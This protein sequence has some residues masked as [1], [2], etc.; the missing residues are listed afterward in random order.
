MSGRLLTVAVAA[1]I[2]AAGFVAPAANASVRPFDGCGAA[3]NDVGSPGNLYAFA[4]HEYVGQVEQQYQV[5]GGGVVNARGHFQWSGTFQARY[6]GFMVTVEIDSHHYGPTGGPST[7]D[8][9]DSKNIYSPAFE[10]HHANP[11]QWWAQASL[12]GAACGEPI[13]RGTDWLYATGS[14]MAGPVEGHC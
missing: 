1:A 12:E 9:E 6:S 3:W 4:D 7:M 14:P 2:A 5:C 13:A 11:D 8:S 10:I